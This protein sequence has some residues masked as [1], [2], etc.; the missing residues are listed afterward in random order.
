MLLK[1]IGKLRSSYIG[2]SHGHGSWS[3]VGYKKNKIFL[4]H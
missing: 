4:A 1:N 3:Y 2:H